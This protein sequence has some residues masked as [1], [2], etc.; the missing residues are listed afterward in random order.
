MHSSS[1]NAIP[2]RRE[3]KDLQAFHDP[4]R[5]LHARLRVKAQGDANYVVFEQDIDNVVK[6][7]KSFTDNGFDTVFGFEA[8]DHQEAMLA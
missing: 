4:L 2:C 5:E 1:P 7:L 6:Q 3:L 8:L